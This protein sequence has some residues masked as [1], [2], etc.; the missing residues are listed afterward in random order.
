MV[1]GASPID[2][3]RGV[4]AA[5]NLFNASNV[6][7]WGAASEEWELKTSQMT[8]RP[9]MLHSRHLVEVSAPR[10]SCMHY[11]VAGGSRDFECGQRIF[12]TDFHDR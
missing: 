5:W 11:G 7:P 3:E 9:T 12:W 4:M 10:H 6:H 2:L 1:P 8:Q